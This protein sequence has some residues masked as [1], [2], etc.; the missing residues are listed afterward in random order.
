MSASCGVL[1]DMKCILVGHAAS[2][3]RSCA[4][5]EEGDL[6]CMGAKPGHKRVILAELHRSRALHRSISAAQTRGGGGQAVPGGAAHKH[7]PVADT[8]GCV[9]RDTSRDPSRIRAAKKMKAGGQSR[10]NAGA[11]AVGYEPSIA[12][13][14]QADAQWMHQCMNDS[15]T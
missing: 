2:G 6:S 8:S 1:L 9:L 14:G 5:V 11:G 10:S 3:S 15:V 4:Q 7:G 13:S 12:P